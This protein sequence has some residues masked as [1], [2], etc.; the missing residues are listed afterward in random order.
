MVAVPPPRV[1]TAVQAQV[2]MG[3]GV[4]WGLRVQVQLELPAHWDYSQPMERNSST[5][6]AVHL[7]ELPLPDR[8]GNPPAQQDPLGTAAAAA[9]T[10]EGAVAMLTG[11]GLSRADA[12]GALL[13]GVWICAR[14]WSMQ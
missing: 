11:Q 14:P 7:V 1:A 8:D 6:A 13:Q 10:D 5:P 12:L 4:N 9:G 3:D 2:L